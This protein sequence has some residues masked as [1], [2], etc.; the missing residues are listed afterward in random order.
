MDKEKLSKILL[1]VSAGLMIAA[2]FT[3]FAPAFNVEYKDG[4]NVVGTGTVTSLLTVLL[5]IKNGSLFT[6]IKVNGEVI[7]PVYDTGS[8]SS[9]QEFG[10]TIFGFIVLAVIVGIVTLILIGRKKYEGKTKKIMSIVTWVILLAAVTLSFLSSVLLDVRVPKAWS[11]GGGIV[12]I[13][14]INNSIGLGAILYGVVGTL[15]LG[16][17]VASFLLNRE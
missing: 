5:H 3:L 12:D 7:K 4:H 8:K 2:F 15:A 16:S 6:F 17:N 14:G 13:G 1:I 10:Y 9:T 11:R